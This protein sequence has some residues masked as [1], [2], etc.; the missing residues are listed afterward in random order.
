MKKTTALLSVTAAALL[1]TGGYVAFHPGVAQAAPTYLQE[2]AKPQ[3]GNYSVDA[4]HTSIVF[5]IDHMGLTNVW[6]RFNEFSGDVNLTPEVTGSSVNVTV[7]AASVDTAVP[8]RD[9][10]LR[11]ADFFEVEKFPT[12]TFVSEQIR[13]EGDSYFADGK[14]TI[15]E[16]TKPV[17]VKFR[18]FGPMNDPRGTTRI[19]V[20]VEPFTIDRRDFGI[21][22]GQ[23]TIGNEVTINIGL[24][25]I[26]KKDS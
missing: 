5:K 21:D 25:A 9:Q 26:L 10:H 2:T 15:R 19:G 8:A 6:G 14:L 11:S 22:Y 20:I 24:E 13:R 17:T 12:L 7:Q 16:I 23:G 4:A 1:V 18:F 3:A